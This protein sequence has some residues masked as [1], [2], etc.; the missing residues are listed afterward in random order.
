MMAHN[1]SPAAKS[2]TDREALRLF[3][4]ADRY[5]ILGN[6]DL[7]EAEALDREAAAKAATAVPSPDDPPEFREWLTALSSERL[8]QNERDDIM[9]ELYALFDPR[10]DAPKNT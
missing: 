6:H 9:E 7:R 1:T 8:T 2:I 10:R 3:W 4:E 5:P